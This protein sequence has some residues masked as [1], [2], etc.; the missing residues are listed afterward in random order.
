M[1]KTQ[2]SSVMGV[3]RISTKK[4]HTSFATKPEWLSSIPPLG[5]LHNPMIIFSSRER[6]AETQDY[7]LVSIQM[8]DLKQRCECC[9]K[10]LLELIFF[11]TGVYFALSHLMVSE[12]PILT[13]F[14]TQIN[15]QLI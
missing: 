12:A 10:N 1:S 6:E 14:K 5:I 2:L 13:A 8:V 15:V 7:S 9:F 3:E 4:P 11:C